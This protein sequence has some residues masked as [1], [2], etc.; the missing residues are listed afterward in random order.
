MTY[1]KA[2]YWAQ[3]SHRPVPG[4]YPITSNEQQAFRR[5]FIPAEALRYAAL[6]YVPKE[7]R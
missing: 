5:A 3:R 7:H 6:C 2:Y 1:A 4:V